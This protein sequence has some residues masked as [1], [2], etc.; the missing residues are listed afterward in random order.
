[1][2]DADHGR[3][4]ERLGEDGRVRRDTA[5]REHDA[6]Q[7]LVLHQRHVGQGELVRDQHDVGREPAL[8]FLMAEEIA[9][10]ALADVADVGGALAEVRVRDGE[11]RLDVLFDDVLEPRLGGLAGP[12][13]GLDL[14]REGRVLEHHPLRVEHRAVDLGREHVHLP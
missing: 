3:D 7:P 13:A 1:M 2:L 12:D 5:G 4:L 8:L 10:H 14:R 11:E 9:Q 6:L